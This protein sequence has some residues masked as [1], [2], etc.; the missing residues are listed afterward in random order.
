[1][2][3]LFDRS[4]RRGR[5]HRETTPDTAPDTTRVAAPDAAPGSAPAADPGANPLTQF[6]EGNGEGRLIHKWLH[7]FDVYDAHFREFVG[8]DITLVEFG[9]S[10]GGSLDMWRSY[11][12]EQARI[13]GVDIDPECAQLATGRTEV[14]IADQE[15]P[16][17]L[18]ALARS[19]GPVDIVID[20]GGHTVLQQK[21]TFDAFYGSVRTPGVYL[22]E[23][24]HTNYWTEFGGG[25][26]RPG[27]FV[28]LAKSQVDQLNAWHSRDPE[29]LQVDEFTRTTSGLHFYDSIIVFTKREVVAP[30]HRQVGRHTLS[31]IGEWDYRAAEAD[32]PTGQ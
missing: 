20:D 14:V 19:I 13:V 28:E 32:A 4:P 10:H 21:N 26:R 30:S 16:A 3:P 18:S 5:R 23:D 1:M 31:R 7:Y 8:R 25:L 12:G 11:F 15:D 27:T 22:V 24:L 6:F 17:Q 9:V 29:S 2:P